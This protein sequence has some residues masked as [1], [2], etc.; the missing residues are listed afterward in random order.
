MKLTSI[1]DKLKGSK[2]PVEA[3]REEVTET[4]HAA[5]GLAFAKIK[6]I[7]EVIQLREIV[8][9]LPD[10]YAGGNI[11]HLL[12]TGSPL[13]TAFKD[14]GAGPVLAG[15]VSPTSNL[16]GGGEALAF[17]TAPDRL[18]IKEWSC[19]WAL[20][21]AP[22]VPALAVAGQINELGRVIEPGGGAVFV[23]WHPYSHAVVSSLSSRKVVDENEGVG[24]EKYFRAFQ[25]AGFIATQVKEAFI[26]GSFR[27]LMDTD[28]EKDWYNKHRRQPFAIMFFLKKSK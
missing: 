28:E 27:K 11:L 21:S 1:L 16:S 7:F 10:D 19:R 5:G 9:R 22:V 3:P 25:K 14:K 2:E 17:R 26:D 4:R 6:E 8:P 20:S 23:D 12:F 18:P 15:Y 24:F 13:T